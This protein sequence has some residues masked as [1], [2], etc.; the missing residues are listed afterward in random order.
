MK[1]KQKKLMLKKLAIRE[2]SPALLSAVVGG[3]G[4][5]AIT[6]DCQ[7]SNEPNPETD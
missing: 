2:L 5:N 7:P 4:T 1:R 6:R 3:D